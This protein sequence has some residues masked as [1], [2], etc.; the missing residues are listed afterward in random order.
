MA[1]FVYTKYSYRRYISIT[2]CEIVLRG[3]GYVFVRMTDGALVTL[4]TRAIIGTTGNSLRSD[5]SFLGQASRCN[6]A[7][8]GNFDG[9]SLPEY[10]VR[11]LSQFSSSA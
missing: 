1:D 4:T 8:L 5:Q 11:S 2:G 10:F 6:F 7:G 9:Y 3:K